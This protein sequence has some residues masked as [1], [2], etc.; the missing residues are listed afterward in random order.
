MIA[1]QYN[2]F[3]SL[4]SWSG[5]AK[6]VYWAMFLKKYFTCGLWSLLFILF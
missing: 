1:L 5:L 6:Y 2:Q 4:Y 3:L